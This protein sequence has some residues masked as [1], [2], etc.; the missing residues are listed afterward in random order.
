MTSNV[1]R[2]RT[3]SGAIPAFIARETEVPFP[4]PAGTGASL[5]DVQRAAHDQREQ[6]TADEAIATGNVQRADDCVRFG[7]ADRRRPYT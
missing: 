1:L 6:V 3:P 5:L 7:I 4:K 2:T